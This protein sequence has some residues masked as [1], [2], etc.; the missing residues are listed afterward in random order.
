MTY[1]YTISHETG[2]ICTSAKR[3]ENELQFDETMRTK[4][5]KIKEYFA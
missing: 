3:Y 1:I 5:N 2:K 4:I